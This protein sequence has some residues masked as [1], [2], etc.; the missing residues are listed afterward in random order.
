VNIYLNDIR[1]VHSSSRKIN[2]ER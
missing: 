1:I 2:I